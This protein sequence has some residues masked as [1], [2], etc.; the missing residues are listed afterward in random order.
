[1][2][3]KASGHLRPQRTITPRFARRY[4]G[5]KILETFSAVGREV[6]VINEEEGV[7]VSSPGT[8]GGQGW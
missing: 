3:A 8:G 5:Q 1:M 6:R 2:A 7:G 4:G